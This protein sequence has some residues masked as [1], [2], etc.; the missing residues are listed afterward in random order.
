ML[1]AGMGDSGIFKNGRVTQNG[2]VVF[3]MNGWGGGRGLFSVGVEYIFFTLRFLN[4]HFLGVISN[5]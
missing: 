1:K 2:G 3:E 5:S 4:F